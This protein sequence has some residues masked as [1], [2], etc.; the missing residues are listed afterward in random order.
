[1][2]ACV[3]RWTSKQPRDQENWSNKLKVARPSNLTVERRG[4]N[5]PQNGNIF[6]THSLTHSLTHLQVKLI[7]KTQKKEEWCTLTQSV[8][9]TLE[10]K[11]TVSKEFFSG[12]QF[13]S[14]PVALRCYGTLRSI[15]RHHTHETIAGF[16]FKTLFPFCS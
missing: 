13:S 4:R 14:A 10:E 8:L 12:V 11:R 15:A 5:N 6:L 16:F 3:R 9:L 7:S 2:R 1:V